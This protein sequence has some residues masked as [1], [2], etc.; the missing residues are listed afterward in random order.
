MLTPTRTPLA[1]RLAMIV[2]AMREPIAQR[3]IRDRVLTVLLGLVYWRLVRMVTRLDRLILRWQSAALRPPGPS[4]AGQPRP[5]PAPAAPPK[6]RL[7]RGRAWL[8][9]LVQP[10]AQFAGQVEHLLADP[11]TARLLA[12]APQAGRIFRPFCR[13]LGI[14]PPPLIRL[15]PTPPRPARP[16]PARPRPARPRPPRP[17]GPELPPLLPLYPIGFRPPLLRRR[18]SPA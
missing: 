16:R 4:R 14:E 13:M 1:G 18:F 5:A 15:P 6:P 3:A 8:I 2:E 17:P 11:E 12:A 9:R 10:T 7:P